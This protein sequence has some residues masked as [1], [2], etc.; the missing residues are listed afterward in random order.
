MK[1]PP[2]GAG[3]RSPLD[4]FQTT[5]NYAFNVIDHTNR[6]AAQ[7]NVL[8]R[9]SGVTLDA[10]DG[11]ALKFV[12]DI[13]ASSDARFVGKFD[14]DDPLN[15]GGNFNVEWNN[16]DKIGCSRFLHLWNQSSFASHQARE[17]SKST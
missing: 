4:P 10:N 17:Y 3:I 2:H 9:L 6:S 11:N 12:R 8:S 7:W 16:S 5:A 14:L 1:Q 13:G 15:K